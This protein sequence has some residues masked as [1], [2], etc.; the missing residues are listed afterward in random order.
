MANLTKKRENY[1]QQF[2]FSSLT[3]NSSKH[4]DEMGQPTRDS[5]GIKIGISKTINQPLSMIRHRT[6]EKVRNQSHDNQIEVLDQQAAPFAER[7]TTAINVR[8]AL[9]SLAS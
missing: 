1:A 9:G 5:V 4:S 6:E 7:K 3:R 2:R 8:E